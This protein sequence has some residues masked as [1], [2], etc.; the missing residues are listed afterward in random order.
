[1]TAN[2]VQ[3]AYATLTN[4]ETFLSKIENRLTL[5][6]GTIKFIVYQRKQRAFLQLHRVS[7]FVVAL[8]S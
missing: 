3:R 1:M 5:K 7:V 8:L 4:V 2:L 6:E